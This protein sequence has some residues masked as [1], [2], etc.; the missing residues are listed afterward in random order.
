MG[1]SD[2]FQEMCG[3]FFGK[4]KIGWVSPKKTYGGY[5]GGYLLLL[6]SYTKY[7]IQSNLQFYLYLDVLE[8]YTFL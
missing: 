3:N 8:I 1:L 6:L 4:H 2:F 5:V 7:I